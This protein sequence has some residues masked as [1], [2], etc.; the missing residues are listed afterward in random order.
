MRLDLRTIQK[1]QRSGMNYDRN[2]SRKNI[3]DKK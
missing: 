2:G 3:E 1:L